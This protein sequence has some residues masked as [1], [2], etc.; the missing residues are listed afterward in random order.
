[1]R[2]LV[3]SKSITERESR[4]LKSYFQELQQLPTLTPEE[5]NKWAVLASNGDE[6]AREKLIN[7]NLR[8]VVSVAKQYRKSG[9]KLEDLINEG[10]YGLIKATST[11]DPSRGFKFISYAVWW[12]RSYILSY[13][14]KNGKTIK[15]PTTKLIKNNQIK[16]IYSL[17]EQE[18]ERPPSY[19]EL[20]ERLKKDYTDLEID[21]FVSNIE[22]MTKSLDAPINNDG[23]GGTLL[24]LIGDT[25]ETKASCFVNSEDSEIRK[26][27]LL[28]R[29]DEIEI[30]VLTLVYGLDGDEPLS[31]IDVSKLLKMAP[32]R[33][34]K[35]KIVALN[36][37]KYNLLK[38]GNW[39]K[40]K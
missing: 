9:I 5:E 34:H 10:N 20:V 36:K 25:N 7:H 32:S 8:F 31:L 22:N 26:N 19:Y 13:I 1:M 37:L 38:E 12:I 11:F 3:I 15:L 16:K 4:S 23:N 39:L 29:L 14:A 35:V 2:D 21:F 6:K 27:T 30:K 24:D 40:N 28:K 18:L 33:V 17:L